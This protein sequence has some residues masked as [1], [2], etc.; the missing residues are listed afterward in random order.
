MALQFSIDLKKDIPVF[1][2][3][4][5]V[6]VHMRVVEGDSERVQVFEGVVIARRG[7][8]ISQSFTVRKISFGVGVERIIPLHS[9]RIQRIEVTKSSKTRR[10]KLYYLRSLRGK[11]ARLAEEERETEVEQRTES[12][13]DKAPMPRTEPPV[14]ETPKAETAP[15][16]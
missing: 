13:D 12:A 10:A 1:K 7:A 3:G 6:R 11:A 14:V 9:P 4:D 2:P 5:T 16:A 15:A 8:G